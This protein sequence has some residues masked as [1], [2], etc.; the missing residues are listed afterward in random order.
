MLLGGGASLTLEDDST[1]TRAPSSPSSVRK[2]SPDPGELSR[3]AVGCSP[4]QQPLVGGGP[5]CGGPGR[6]ALGCGHSQSGEKRVSRFLGAEG[7]EGQSG[8]WKKSFV[9]LLVCLLSA[10]WRGL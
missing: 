8:S 4:G 3:E 1:M 6:G 2:P 5:V 9:R 10:T 7:I